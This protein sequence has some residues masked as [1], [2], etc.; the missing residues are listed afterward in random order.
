M[1]A[2]AGALA[3]AQ[4]PLP[5]LEAR[6]T[7]LTGTLTAAQQA[8]LEDKLIALEKRKGAQVAVLIVPT[9]EPEDI[10]QFGIRLADRARK[11]G[12]RRHLHRRPR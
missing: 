12:R 11:T 3:Q 4:V 1:L 2:I 8:A 9:T 6:V 5:K 10:A 7:D